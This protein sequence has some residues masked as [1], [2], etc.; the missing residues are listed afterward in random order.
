[1][2][3]HL[4]THEISSPLP[5]QLAQRALGSI[6]AHFHHCLIAG[7]NLLHIK[8]KIAPRDGHTA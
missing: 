3:I 8:D 4:S 7:P 1:M 5:K 6:G 2:V